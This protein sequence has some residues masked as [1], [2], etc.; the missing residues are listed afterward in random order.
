MLLGKYKTYTQNLST[1]CVIVMFHFTF[2]VCCVLILSGTYFFAR[3]LLF[4]T[5]MSHI[6]L[7]RDC[8][9]IFPECAVALKEM[10]DIFRSKD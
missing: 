1:E 6:F 7:S 4:R 2:M 9:I 3:I 5:Y 10:N 8:S